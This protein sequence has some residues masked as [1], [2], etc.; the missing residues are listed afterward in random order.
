MLAA[1]KVRPHRAVTP[2]PSATASPAP[3]GRAATAPAREHSD[4]ESPL[5]KQGRNGSQ[6]GT[7]LLWKLVWTHSAPWILQCAYSRTT[8]KHPV[9]SFTAA[10]MNIKKTPILFS[11][12]FSREIIVAYLPVNEYWSWAIPAE[13]FNTAACY[14]L[15]WVTTFHSTEDLNLPKF[16]LTGETESPA[17]FPCQHLLFALL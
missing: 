11:Y 6:W 12:L 5:L 13:L 16:C 14:S 1:A 8:S 2:V 9:F 17:K 3:P 7:R 15:L 10:N 4:R